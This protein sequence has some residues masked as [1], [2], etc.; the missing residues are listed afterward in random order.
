MIM[1]R[2]KEN[3]LR[4]N[5]ELTFK[6]NRY[7][8]R[9]GWLR[10]TPAYSVK[11]VDQILDT[12]PPGIAVLDPFSGTGTTPLSAAYRNDR[13]TGVEINP[14]LAWLGK[15]K[16]ARYT[17]SVL[18]EARCCLDE[19]C[20]LVSARPILPIAPPLIHDIQRWWNDSELTFLCTLKSA[21]DD[22]VTEQGQIRDLFLVGFCRILMR[23]SNAAFNHQSMSFRGGN[24]SQPSLFDHD[25]DFWGTFRKEMLFVLQSASDNPTGEA[26]VLSGDA[27]DIS[28]CLS[29]KYDLLIT[30]P[31][32]PNRMS[33]IRELRPY[34]YWLGYLKNAREAGELDW[35]AIGGTWGVA[36]SRLAQWQRPD[37][38]F[39]PTSLMR[40]LDDIAHEDNRSG[41][42]LSNY[43]AKYFSDMWLHMQQVAKVIADGGTVHYVVGNSVFYNVLV[44]VERLYADMLHAAG[45]EDVQISP[46]RKRSSKKQL[47]EYD[48]S[49]KR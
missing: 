44:P 34:M 49:A 10:L 47:Y 30:S 42:L 36:T 33:Y 1:L 32:Y 24:S 19:I 39:W 40:A 4:Q 37:N 13:G 43:I 21:I 25:M 15:A 16:V 27:R 5:A 31:P 9:H 8:G 3:V 35:S 6:Y 29:G 18:T 14:F 26:N 17:P 11:L 41:L 46:I 22:T 2:T 28:S 48:V 23:L 20:N 12:S 7:H 45:F 38:G